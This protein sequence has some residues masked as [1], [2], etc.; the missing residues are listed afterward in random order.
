MPEVGKIYSYVFP[1]ERDK[2]ENEQ[3]VFKFKYLSCRVHMNE[4]L[5]QYLLFN[6]NLTAEKPDA[7]KAMAA[8]FEAVKIALVGWENVQDRNGGDPLDFNI[9]DLDVI[10]TSVQMIELMELIIAGG[11]EKPQ[12]ITDETITEGLKASEAAAAAS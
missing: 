5:P 8:C 10:V 7:K 12:V 6:E 11:R 4:L 2:P 3:A 9:D 1:K